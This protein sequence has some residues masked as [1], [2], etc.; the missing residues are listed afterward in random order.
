[1]TH[2]V[3]PPEILCVIIKF[4]S[5]SS[6]KQFRLVNKRFKTITDSI[7]FKF[8]KF[9][10]SIPLK[11]LLEF[12]IK[13]LTASQIKGSISVLPE[14]LNVFI[15][16]VPLNLTM[17]KR[18]PEI[19]F[20]FATHVMNEYHISNYLEENVK[21]YTT[22]QS[23]LTV[24]TLKKLQNLTFKTLTVS[25]IETFSKVDSDV[26][27][28][29]HLSQLKI[30]RLILD[31]GKFDPRRLIDFKNITYISSAI[32]KRYE[33]FPLWLISKLPSLEIVQF[34]TQTYLNFELFK[35]LKKLYV[36]KTPF[37]ESDYTYLKLFHFPRKGRVRTRQT[38]SIFF[39][40]LPS[41]WVMSLQDNVFP[42]KQELSLIP[43]YLR[44]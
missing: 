23:V 13:E 38:T 3:I 24:R 35:N 29:E 2:Q 28:I 39:K 12:P 15:I 25:H 17:I 1:M 33:D 10:S 16:D 18:N 5:K 8:P 27:L 11:H 7:I 32:F 6:R 14:C 42:E 22:A 20:V 9:T 40:N 30:E 19:T 44:I 4:L 31:K 26:D 41:S 43:S 21:I 36:D 34:V 37:I